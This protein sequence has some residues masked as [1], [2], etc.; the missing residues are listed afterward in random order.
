MPDASYTWAE[1]MAISISHEMADGDFGAVGAA[2]HIPAAGLRL[3]QLTHAPGLSFFCG[4]SGATNPVIQRLTESSA[5]H[6]NLVTSEYQFS[7]EDVVDF[8]AAMRFDFAFLGGMQIDKHGNL[9]MAMIGD[10]ARP[11]VRGPGSVGLIFLGGFRTSY[12][13][14]EHHSPRIFVDKV[15]FISGAGWLDGGDSRSKVFRPESDGPRRVFTPLGVFDFE[16]ESKRMR[17]IK[18]HP[19]STIEQIQQA[20]GF[21][22]LIADEVRTVDPPTDEELRLL[23]TQVDRDGVLRRYPRPA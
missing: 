16:P 18:V 17:L 19:W 5:D 14:V 10:W 9:N 7:L 11:K 6:R 15:D 3:A 21:E 13:Y 1:M 20:T 2:S 4:G 8:E 12:I 23:R 22:L